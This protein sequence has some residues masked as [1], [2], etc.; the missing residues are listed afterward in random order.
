MSETP[1]I[2]RVKERYKTDTEFQ[3]LVNLMGSMMTEKGHTVLDL[4]NAVALAAAIKTAKER[5]ETL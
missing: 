1:E 2:E 5:K 3:R 4:A